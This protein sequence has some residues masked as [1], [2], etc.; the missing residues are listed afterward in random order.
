VDPALREH[1]VRHYDARGGAVP[2]L[3]FDHVGASAIHSSVHDLIR[4]GM[5]HLRNEVLGQQRI[6]SEGT[7]DM[8]HEPSDV[9][10]PDE[11]L[12]V[13][14][15]LGWAIVDLEGVRMVNVTGGMPGTVTRLALIPTE[16]A[17]VAIMINNGIG[18]AYA[19][20]EIERETFAAMIPDLPRGPEIVEESEPAEPLPAALQGVWSGSIKTHQ[21]DLP[22]SLTIGDGRE[23]ELEIDGRKTVPIRVQSPLGRVRFT[24]GVFEAPFFGSIPTDDAGRSRHVLFLRLRK[25]GDTLSGVVAA[26]A[27]NQTFWLPYRTELGRVPEG[28]RRR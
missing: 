25:R 8:M 24:D 6:L 3:D 16:N 5:F 1:A 17:A 20:W 26:V 11:V 18:D 23:M 19:P 14:L 4:Y 13:R 15:G 10:M 9:S 7:I 28:A 27:M 2:A 12:E 22:A 21:G